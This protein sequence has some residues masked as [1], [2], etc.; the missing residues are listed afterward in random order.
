MID[1]LPLKRNDKLSVQRLILLVCLFAGGHGAALAQSDDQLSQKLVAARIQTISDSGNEEDI[2][3]TLK[4]YDQALNWLKEADAFALSTERYTE[5]LTTAPRDEAL[6][7][8]RMD[9][10]DPDASD[11]DPEKLS[12]L[13]WPELQKQSSAKRLELR[14]AINTKGKQDLGLNTQNTGAD[15]INAR[16]AEITQRDQELP[17]SIVVVD[18]QASPSQFEASQWALAAE[19]QV[20]LAERRSLEARLISQPVRYSRRRAERDEINLKIEVLQRDLHIMER[21]L[22]SHEEKIEGGALAN[23]Q[24]NEPGY[25][26]VKQITDEVSLLRS[27]RSVITEKLAVLG[28]VN[29]RVQSQYLALVDQFSAARRI[30]DLA[31]DSS[32]F[33]SV[34]MAYW[35]HLDN[36]EIVSRDMN[37]SREVGDV[38]IQKSEHEV[39]LSKLS[40]TTSYVTSLF[41]AVTD[42]QDIAPGISEAVRTIAM[43]QVQ[44]LR[45]YL[46]ELITVE[47]RMIEIYSKIDLAHSQTVSLLEEYEEFL[48]SRILWE[49]NHPPVSMATLRLAPGDLRQ[50]LSEIKTVRLG[51]LTTAATFLLIFSLVLIGLRKK[52]TQSL[53]TVNRKIGRA[54][55]DSIRFTL[56]ALLLTLVRCLPAPLLLIGLAFGLQNSGVNASETLAVTLFLIAKIL[57]IVLLLRNACGEQGIASLH[58]DWPRTICLKIRAMMNW[59]LVWL[60]LALITDF[61]LTLELDNVRSGFSRFLLGLAIALVTV[62]LSEVVWPANRQK[63]EPVFLE[64][65][66]VVIAIAI[67]TV[68][69]VAILRGYLYTARSVFQGVGSSLLMIIVLSFF[70]SLMARWLLVT[71]RKLRLRE[72]LA[73]RQVT[74]NDDALTVEPDEVNLVDLSEATAEMLKAGTLLFGAV[75]LLYVWAPLFPAFQAFQRVTLWKINE[76]VDG[77]AVST[78]ITLA[79][80]V[81]AVLIGTITFYAARRVPALFALVL[82]SRSSISRGTRYTA[83]TLLSYLIVSIG[84]LILLS[85]LGLRWDQLQWLVAALG[86]GIGFGL[87]EIIANF[88]SGLIILFERPIRIGD[89][90]TVGESS[91]MVTRIRIRA[92]TIREWDG[93]ELLVPNKEFVT[94]RLLNWTLSDPTI[95]VTLE[96]GI[97]YG[98]DV[99]KA[100]AILN[101]VVS[102]HALALEDP[103]P[104]ILFREFGNDSLQMNA[105]FFISKPEDRW[106]IQ[107]EMHEQVYAAFEDAGIVIAFPQR[108]VHF[109][110]SSPIPVSITNGKPNEG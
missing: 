88:I 8:A 2:D 84:V 38:V 106:Q 99:K 35:K 61:A 6:I 52:I 4:V 34:L 39:M 40:S 21:V 55:D 14:E 92:T 60:P 87:Q 23:L 42:S 71:R 48:A 22:A 67:A 33:G 102:N 76:T 57:Y 98:S 68:L 26:V 27:Q 77:V 9:A 64:R 17:D 15:N 46:K 5:A 108:D 104:M 10:I 44:L 66:G 56:I 70:Y 29:D 3:T 32:S 51:G 30:V 85:T 93:K 19:R 103:S 94:G 89:L 25:A 36:I 72:L 31:G 28:E 97:A 54:R 7:R 13:S 101:D 11:I 18:P 79:T 80:L 81:L 1:Q 37:V 91:G 47:S 74:E 95:R 109:D 100:M 24:E 105:R 75:G 63:D 83:V 58:F 73:S 49:P 78:N 12:N 69:I 53:V 82:R 59:I 16:L 43:E 41:A 96:V 110:A 62:K 107:S 90:V 50:T 45:N 86:V 20:L 65:A